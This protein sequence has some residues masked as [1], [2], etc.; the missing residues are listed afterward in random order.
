[1]ETNGT[2][3]KITET[4]CILAYYIPK[5]FHNLEL[6]VKL[7]S[8]PTKTTYLWLLQLPQVTLGGDSAIGDS[9][10]STDVRSKR[11]AGAVDAM[12]SPQSGS[13][14]VAQPGCENGRVLKQKRVWQNGISNGFSRGQEVE[15]KIF[16]W[17]NVDSGGWMI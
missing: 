2:P 14:L 17:Y 15:N 7:N 5:Q 10:R 8:G 16:S 6:H 11:G 13:I 3:C 4:T 1:M 12:A 9:T